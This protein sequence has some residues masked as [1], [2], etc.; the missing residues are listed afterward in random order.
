MGIGD[1]FNYWVSKIGGNSKDADAAQLRI[2]QQKADALLQCGK[3]HEAVEL[4]VD[5]GDRGRAAAIAQ[6]AGL[7]K[8]AGELHESMNKTV[9]AARAFERA[10]EWER[11]AKLHESAGDPRNAEACY[12]KGGGS[13]LRMYLERRG[14][15]AGA[16]KL[17]EEAGDRPAAATCYEKAK[18]IDSA[19]RCLRAENRLLDLADLLKRHDMHERAGRIYEETGLPTKAAE[20]YSVGNCHRDALR[21][22]D[23]MARAAIAQCRNA[24]GK[25]LEDARAMARRAAGHALELGE[26]QIAGDLFERAG[27]LAR[28]AECFLALKPEKAAQLFEK[29]GDRTR[30]AAAREAAG[31][32][33]GAE[34]L[35][36]KESDPRRAAQLLAGRGQHAE[37]A[38]LFAKQGLL[39]ESAVELM[40]AGKYLPAAQLL[41][42]Q[43]DLAGAAEAYEGAGVFDQAERLF[44]HTGNDDGL[45]RLYTRKGDQRE[46]A[47]IHIRRKNLDAAV[48]ALQGAEQ[49]AETVALLAH[50]FRELGMAPQALLKFEELVKH[51][52]LKPETP[53]LYYE[54]ARLL[55]E[56]G[57]KPEAIAAY[58]AILAVSLDFG[59]VGRRLKKLEAPEPAAPP[60]TPVP[61]ERFEIL[62]EIGRGGQGVVWRA[63]DRLLDRTV[64]LKSIHDPTGNKGLLREARSMA[65]LVHP[66]I[67]S[68][69]EVFEKGEMLYM[70]LEFLEGETLQTWTRKGEPLPAPGVIHVAKGVLAAL[71]HAHGKGMIH[72]DIK[73][74]NIMLLEDGGV[75]VL[76]FGLAKSVETIELSS[77]QCGT[78]YYMA[79]EQILCRRPDARTDLYALG[80]TLYQALTGKAPFHG[81]DIF[82]QH[83]NCQPAPVRSH[84]PDVPMKLDVLILQCLEKDP[85]FRPQSARAILDQLQSI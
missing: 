77:T 10:Q 29:A 61:P 32:A 76:D 2:V 39:K 64:A 47:R 4:L 7:W 12:R 22:L 72:R 21:L 1:H 40:A 70:V 28:A 3:G 11:A 63:R 58:N 80:V 69:F 60:V 71:E 46:L 49:D 17:C 6:K 36:A 52:A 26:K 67:V 62:K 78:P 38:A 30:A 56:L 54:Y 19:E 13:A 82:F 42:A 73:P 20:A 66:N 85:E 5:A 59:D 18:D 24:A 14:D 27:D 51:D 16:G 68:L 53:A 43:G 41:H 79:P 44:R 37:A 23:P 25:I 84:A 75:K 34:L 74:S 83:L 55:E 81:G 8:R 50:C 57:R 45:V 15:W 35:R 9:D 33:A 48:R 31:D 65:A